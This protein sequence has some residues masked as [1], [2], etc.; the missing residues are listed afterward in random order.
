VYSPFTEQFIIDKYGKKKQKELRNID[1]RD[2]HITED[3]NCILNAE[4][5]Y[6]TTHTTS[7]PQGGFRTYYV[8]H[9][10]DII[11]AKI[12]PSG[13]LLWAR[14][15]NKAQTGTINTSYT[16]T[17]YNGK[18]YF[19]IN[20]SDKIRKLKNN[21]IQFK[22]IKIKRSNL[23]VISVDTDGNFEYKKILDDKESPKKQE[24]YFKGVVIKTRYKKASLLRL[25]SV[26][27]GSLF[28]TKSKI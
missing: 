20:G 6:I 9:Y 2:I 24:A 18:N 10:N 17:Y 3:N 4:E 28:L 11:T 25:R 21:R 26:T 15:I 14:N 5:F 13:N 19:F 16:S 23:Y 8:Y 1:F 27:K 7:S 22:D 12:D